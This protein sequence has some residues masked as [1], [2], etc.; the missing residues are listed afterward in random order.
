VRVAGEPTEIAPRV[1]DALRQAEPGLVLE[2]V[3]AMS[4]RVTR[5]VGRERIVAYLAAGFAAIALF[6]ASLGLYGTLSYAVAGRT[7]EIGVRMA[8]GAQWREVVGLVVRD[9]ATVVAAGVAVGAVA[10]FV[11]VRWL[12]A[13][14]FDVTASDPLT[15][16]IVLAV[17]VVVTI[18]AAYLPA[19]RAALVDPVIALR[20]V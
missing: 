5:D 13:L 16:M 7:R 8:L 19:R 9:A 3:A 2:G 20:S 12:S 1:R 11:T 4:A 15:N 10:A 14:L 6:L 18:L 17:L